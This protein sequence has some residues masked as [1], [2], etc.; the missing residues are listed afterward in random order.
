MILR[1]SWYMSSTRNILKLPMN[2]DAIHIA[3]T[4]E[5]AKDVQQPQDHCD[6]HRDIQNLLDLA[7]HRDV[8]VNQPQE[9]PNNYQS[10]HQRN[11][12]H[13]YFPLSFAVLSVLLFFL[14]QRAGE[15]IERLFGVRARTIITAIIVLTAI[16]AIFDIPEAEER[17]VGKKC[18][19]R[20]SPYH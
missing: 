2:S 10:D 18:R 3:Q 1:A 4:G 12:Y 17:R 16:T 20:W 6:D 13:I 14:A 15:S 5:H 9:H 19:A 7:I 8:G 11:N